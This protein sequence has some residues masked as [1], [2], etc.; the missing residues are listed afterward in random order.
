MEM[1]YDGALVM[2]NSFALVAEDE[3]EYIDG[4]WSPST[5]MGNLGRFVARVGA[6]CVV[7]KAASALR[8]YVAAHKGWGYAKM[9][10]NAAGKVANFIWALPCW[11]KVA[12]AGGTAAAV[13]ALG[14][15]N[16]F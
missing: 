11:A 1:C 13:W 4:G 9:L 5:M 14:T 16:I 3:M 12:L 8:T 2:P 6:A 15:W 7:A 10:A